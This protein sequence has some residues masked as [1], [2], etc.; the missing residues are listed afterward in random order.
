MAPTLQ[1]IRREAKRLGASVTMEKHGDSYRCG[2]EAP[3]GY[4]WGC[5]DIHEIVDWSYAPWK[6]DYEDILSR[7]KYGVEKCEDEDC[8]WCHPEE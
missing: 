6:P 4:K 1:T 5:D 3:A 7:M 8:D 2:V